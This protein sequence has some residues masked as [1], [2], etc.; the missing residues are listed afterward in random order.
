MNINDEKCISIH[1]WPYIL[2]LIYIALIVTTFKPI[3]WAVCLNWRPPI[4]WSQGTMPVPPHGMP[5]RTATTNAGGQRRCCKQRRVGAWEFSTWKWREVRIWHGKRPWWDL[6]ELVSCIGILRETDGQV[7][8]FRFCFFLRS[9][10]ESSW[11]CWFFGVAGQDE[12]I[13]TACFY[14]S[15]IN[16]PRKDNFDEEPKQ[17]QT[18]S[19]FSLEYNGT[20]WTK[21]L[22]A[23]YNKG[24]LLLPLRAAGGGRRYLGSCPVTWIRNRRNFHQ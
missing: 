20:S 4:C 17:I 1:I 11:V 5:Q 12:N 8:F 19:V 9:L 2:Q 14:H 21:K 7:S 13:T 6:K 16:K 15:T 18:F 3:I 23:S 22:T 10:V 24:H